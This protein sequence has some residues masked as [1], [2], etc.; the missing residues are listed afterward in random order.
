MKIVD[1]TTRRYRGKSGSDYSGEV[2]IVDVATDD[3]PAGMGFA[4]GTP[5]SGDIINAM[6]TNILAPAI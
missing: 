4:F 2:L 6:I 5:G 3:G 1:V